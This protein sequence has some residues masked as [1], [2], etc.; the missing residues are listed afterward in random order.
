MRT[1]SSAPAPERAGGWS[2]LARPLFTAFLLGCVVSLLAS[3]SLTLAR[4]V[5]ASVT[6]SWVPL[7][8]ILSLAAVWRIGPRPIP[9][10]RA[11]DLFCA[12]NAPWW[13]WLIAFAAFWSLLPA[14][15]WLASAAAVAVWSG[16][17]DY[18][19]FR[20]TLKS[21]SPARD[22]LAGRV[23]AWTPGILLFGG[24]SLWPGIVERLK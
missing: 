7:F 22:L 8:E 15:I 3:G 14:R 13:L 18:R 12:G 23:V 21:A 20:F 6:W 16:R 9:F 17:T 4:V 19:F 2:W 24:A 11:V 1:P 10:T 5:P